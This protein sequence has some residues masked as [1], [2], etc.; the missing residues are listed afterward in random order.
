MVKSRCHVK[1]GNDIYNEFDVS[2][3]LKQGDGLGPMVFKQALE[4]VIRAPANS[5]AK[6]KTLIKQKRSFNLI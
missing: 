1:V 6:L 3:G 4:N 2:A 5:S